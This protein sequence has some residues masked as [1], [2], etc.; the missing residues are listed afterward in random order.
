MTVIASKISFLSLCLFHRYIRGD[1]VRLFTFPSTVLKLGVSG[2]F[3]V[4]GRLS[5][6][7]AGTI[8]RHRMTGNFWLLVSRIGLKI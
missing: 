5:R 3:G 6:R 4:R 7:T 1:G 2:T 8:T